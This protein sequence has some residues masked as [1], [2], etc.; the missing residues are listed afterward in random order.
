M[1]ASDKEKFFNIGAQLVCDAADVTLPD[2]YIHKE[3]NT[4]LDN[5]VE[6]QKLFCKAGSAIFKLAGMEGCIEDNILKHCASYDRL[7][8]E[9]T[10][11]RFIE[12]VKSITKQAS[13]VGKILGGLV[14]L[15]PTGL[16]LSLGALAGIGAA[17]GAVARGLY[18]G[19]TQDTM[20]VEEKLMQARKYKALAHRLKEE[21]EFGELAKTVRAKPSDFSIY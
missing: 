5:S 7:L 13:T 3:A 9:E 18:G 17:G 12:P 1:N 6:M 16:V 20:K 19:A 2:L 10:H 21:M 11:A 15:T 14:S 4:I 8:S